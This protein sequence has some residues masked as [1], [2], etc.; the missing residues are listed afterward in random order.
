MAQTDA[1]TLRPEIEIDCHSSANDIIV[2]DI[3]DPA[4]HAYVKGVSPL[5]DSPDTVP[6]ARFM[7]SA[8]DKDPPVLQT[9]DFWGRKY[10]ASCQYQWLP[11]YFDVGPDGTSCT[12]CDY[13]N[14]LVPRSQYNDLYQSLQELFSLALPLLESVYSYCRLVKRDHLHTWQPVPPPQL[15]ENAVSLSSQR[16]QVITKIFHYE[17]ATLGKLKACPTRRLLP[18]QCMF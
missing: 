8:T 10:E 12:I 4:F 2:R 1:I 9:I 18:H 13:I 5:V 11:T 15:E 16:L 3:V 17:L 7:N 6:P 14:N